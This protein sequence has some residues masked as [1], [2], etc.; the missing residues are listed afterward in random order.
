MAVIGPVVTRLEHPT[1]LDR[2]A[3]WIFYGE[4]NTT[5]LIGTLV[6]HSEIFAPDPEW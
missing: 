6:P 1:E 3:A 4:V 2:A 5:L